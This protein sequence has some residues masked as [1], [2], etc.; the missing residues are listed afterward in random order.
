M[1]AARAQAGKRKSV[2][3]KK[4]TAKDSS[5]GTSQP[6]GASGSISVG[7]ILGEC[8]GAICFVEVVMHSL[9]SRDVGDA[10]QEV[11]KRALRLIWSVH[12]WIEESNPDDSD[13]MEEQGEDAP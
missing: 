11:L 6:Q 7:S 10:E 1:S 2:P 5:Q 3:A 9:E 4:K 13:D 8:T 12:D